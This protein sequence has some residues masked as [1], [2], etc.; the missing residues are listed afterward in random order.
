MPVAGRSFTLTCDHGSTA[1]NPIYQWLDDAGAMVG[2]QATLTLNPLL[3]SH[4]GEYSCLVTDQSNGLVGCGVHRVTVQG[5][6][7]VCVHNY[8]CVSKMP[9]LSSLTPSS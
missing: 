6:D 7:W 8:V 2:I 3:E 9:N 5:R 4:R 1:S